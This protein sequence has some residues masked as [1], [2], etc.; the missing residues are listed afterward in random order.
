[1][2]INKCNMPVPVPSYG[3]LELARTSTS[4]LCSGC[5]SC[6]LSLLLSPLFPPV[7]PCVCS[8]ACPPARPRLCAPL[9]AELLFQVS[10]LLPLSPGAGP[11]RCWCWALHPSAPG[12]QAATTRNECRCRKPESRERVRSILWLVMLF[13]I[14]ICV[15]IPLRL[16]IRTH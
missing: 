6:P 8:P 13:C 9:A 14:C 12:S 15:Q 2:P 4:G 16:E 7:Q 11:S 5:S 1:M 3:I 10:P